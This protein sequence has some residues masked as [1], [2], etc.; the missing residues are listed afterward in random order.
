[1][2]N[3][4]KFGL[5]DGMT[6]GKGFA[7]QENKGT[8]YRKLFEQLL[9]EAGKRNR[10]KLYRLFAEN[11]D[12]FDDSFAQLVRQDA[13]LKLRKSN[14]RQRGIQADKLFRFGYFIYDFPRGNRA[15]NLEIAIACYEVLSQFYPRHTSPYLWAILQSELGNY[16]QDRIRGDRQ[17]NLKHAISLYQAALKVFTRETFPEYWAMTQMNLGNVYSDTE[18][19]EQ[20]I[21]AYQ[22][23]LE[24]CTREASPEYWADT[25]NNLGTAYTET[26][27]FEQA[28]AAYQNSLE[29][30]TREASPEDWATTQ[31][32]LGNA[33]REAGKSEQA[34]SFLKTS[35]E[36]HTREAFPEDWAKAQYNLATAYSD[37]NQ[38]EEAFT[39][40]RSCLEIF[41]PTAFPLRR[42]KAGRDFGHFAFKVEEWSK[43][44]EGY[45]AAIEAVETSCSWV[46]TNQRRQ[47]I[48]EEAIDVYT[49]V[50]PACLNNQQPDLAIEYVE[51]SKARNLVQI[52]ADS[53]EQLKPKGEEIR[54]STIKKLDK[55]KG[56]I[57]DRQQQLDNLGEG[58]QLQATN[59]QRD[60]QSISAELG[61]V[62]ESQPESQPEKLEPNSDS[63]GTE[64]EEQESNPNQIYAQRLREELE[65]LQNQFDEVLEEIILLD[66]AYALTQAVKPIRYQDIL[67]QLDEH[68]AVIEWFLTEE[69]F[70]T[71]LISHHHSQPYA[72]QSSSEQLRELER[73]QQE[74]L[75]DYRGDKRAWIEQ[76][77]SRLT[78]LGTILDIDEIISKIPKECK[79]LI[80]IP[81]RYLHLF[82]LH[83]LKAR[84]SYLLDL[85]PQGVRYA[86]SCQLLELSKKRCSEPQ[87]LPV[88]DKRLFAIQNPTEDLNFAKAEVEAIKG[89][90]EPQAKILQEKQATKEVWNKKDTKKQ[91]RLANFIH[92]AGHGYFDFKFPLRSTLTLNGA[93]ASNPKQSE[94]DKTRYLQ[95]PDGDWIDREKSILL[96]EIFTLDVRPCRLVTLSA[97]ETALTDS[98]SFTDEYIGLP[99]GFLVAGSPSIVASLW[100]VDDRATAFLM[101]KFYQ[102]IIEQINSSSAVSLNQISIATALNQAQRWLRDVTKEEFRKWLQLLDIDKEHQEE[103]E[104]DLTLSSSDTPFEQ[105]LYWAAFC[106]IGQ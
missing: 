52:F 9:K 3:E 78:K 34:I 41:K 24:V 92:F 73:W 28:I 38:I 64:S 87:S 97:C 102:N 12:K 61:I 14:R 29:V 44:R 104:I 70:Y 23:S 27:Q 5:L 62:E 10:K 36:V 99:S 75:Q 20:A 74:Y 98:K 39:H 90:F 2:K 58:S 40:F 96:E 103:V 43:A 42:V 91:L 100:A 4:G 37:L 32:N 49:K 31:N 71:F 1:M 6:S 55:L 105:P 51:R 15:S 59:L 106:T 89:Y 54:Q 79:Q 56:K 47:E 16:Y 33:Y 22:N 88:T 68:T 82:P 7:P 50:V 83:A 19:F 85:Y 72:W 45:R 65:D 81:H 48:M 57:T 95:S 18:Q 25:Q 30:R 17:E 101:I 69:R 94:A 67:A 77:S 8:T 66:P 13:E 60:V 21:A 63:L 86:P 11:Q 84:D 46:S 26:E 80:L 35:L 53:D 93:N 76:L